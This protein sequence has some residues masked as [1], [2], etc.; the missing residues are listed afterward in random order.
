MGPYVF[1][2]VLNGLASHILS[3]RNISN[4]HVISIHTVIDLE[5]GLDLLLVHFSNVPCTLLSFEAQFRPP[6]VIVLDVLS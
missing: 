4:K 5:S 6:K 3:V 1:E 2:Y